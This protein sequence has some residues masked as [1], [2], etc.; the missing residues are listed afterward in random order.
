[1]EK[2]SQWLT[3]LKFILVGHKQK[4]FVIAKDMIF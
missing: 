2:L 3:K 1:M 4:Q